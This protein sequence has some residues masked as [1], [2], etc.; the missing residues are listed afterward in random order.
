MARPDLSESLTISTIPLSDKKELT[1]IKAL[2]I[3][4]EIANAMEPCAIVSYPFGQIRHSLAVTDAPIY[5]KSAL[6]SV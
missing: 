6:D 5:T 1:A 4:I 2:S 3:E